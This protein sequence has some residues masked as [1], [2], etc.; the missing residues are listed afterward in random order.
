MRWLDS[1]TDLMGMGLSKLREFVMDREAW[2]AAIHGI[3]KSLTRLSDWTE[4]NW[5]SSNIYIFYISIYITHN[6]ATIW[7]TVSV[8]FQQLNLLKSLLRIISNDLIKKSTRSFQSLFNMNFLQPLRMM[9][10]PYFQKTLFSLGFCRTIFSWFTSYLWAILLSALL[11][12]SEV[13]QF[14]GV[15]IIALSCPVV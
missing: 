6:Q 4:L 12:V 1:I 7:K 8:F 15:L 10:Y 11:A 14:P 5:R 2:S 9:V 13:L 3:A